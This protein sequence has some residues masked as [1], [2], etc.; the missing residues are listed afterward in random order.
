MTD[1]QNQFWKM[2]TEE[3][4][5]DKTIDRPKEYG[6]D[7]DYCS[8]YYGMLIRQD[9]SYY[10]RNDRRKYYRYR[11]G[12]GGSGHI[13]PTPLHVAR[14]AI[15]RLTLPEDCVL[16]PFLGSGT[17][18]V[19]ALNHNRNCIGIELDTY[20]LAE[21]N[22]SLTSPLRRMYLSKQS[23]WEIYPG[24]ARKMIDEVNHPIQLTILHPPYSGDEQSNAKYDRDKPANMAFMK[25]S[26]QYW[27]DMEELF[28]KIKQE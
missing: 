26:E 14:W 23:D 16:D 1:N 21:Q 12:Q 11:H 19:E 6:C 5:L 13:N 8:K 9:G 24:D 2:I 28:Y 18:M 7:C 4:N 17:T 25:E 3:I 22:V 10:N 20:E 27:E 15:Q